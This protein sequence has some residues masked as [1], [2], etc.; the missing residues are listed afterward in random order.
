MK[1]EQ[2]YS[3]LNEGKTKCGQLN[4]TLKTIEHCSSKLQVQYSKAQNDIQETYLFYLQ[5]LDQQRALQLKELE[6]S[7]NTKLL[8]LSLLNSK[9]HDSIDKMNQMSLFLERFN[10]FNCNFELLQFKQLLESRL[11]QIKHF[12]PEMNLPKV[13]LEFVNNYQAIQGTGKR[14]IDTF[15]SSIKI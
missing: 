8:T 13:D 10:K 4:V 2:L 6:D 7:Y 14:I 11:K 5:Q 9:V 1:V 12:E 15:L 3:M